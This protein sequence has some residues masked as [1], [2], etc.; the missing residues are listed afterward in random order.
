MLCNGCSQSTRECSF[1]GF[2]YIIKD[3]IVPGLPVTSRKFPHGLFYE[4]LRLLSYRTAYFRNRM[5]Y[6]T[7]IFVC[8]WQHVVRGQGSNPQSS[9]HEPDELAIYSTPQLISLGGSFSLIRFL[10]NSLFYE[11]LC[12]QKLSSSRALSRSLWNKQ[13]ITIS[14]WKDPNIARLAYDTNELQS[15]TCH[16]NLLQWISPFRFE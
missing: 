2:P 1:N 14:S 5:D 11:N 8:C 13:G 4:N 12:L 15:R 9:G 7:R 6:S 16:T 3:S 10:G